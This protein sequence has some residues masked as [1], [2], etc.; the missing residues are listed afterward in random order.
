MSGLV[1]IL[2]KVGKRMKYITIL[3]ISFLV[4]LTCIYLMYSTTSEEN[5]ALNKQI[6]GT[7][8]D[9]KILTDGVK[10][11]DKYIEM[12]DFKKLEQYFIIVMGQARYINSIKLYWVKGFQ[13]ASYKVEV[14]K[15][16]FN[17]DL[18]G[19]YKKIKPVSEKGGLIVTRHF[20]ENKAAFFIKVTILQPK[21]KTVRISEVELF[22]EVSAILTIKNQKVLNIK[23]HSVDI[24]FNTSIAAV[25]YLRFGEGK[26]SLT[27]NIGMKMDVFAKHNIH[28][29]NLLKGTVYFYQP[30]TRDLNGKTVIGKV[31][32]FKT[33]G[34]PL[35][36][37]K[38]VK[39]EEIQCF[40][41]KLRWDLNVPCRNELLLG[42]SQKDLKSCYK[43]NQM[44]RKNGLEISKL[45][46]ET[47]FYF[48][49]ISTDKFQNKIEHLGDF[50]TKAENIALKK[51]VY[52]TFY[53][54]PKARGTKYDLKLF[55]RITDGNYELEGI[56]SSG[57]LNNKDQIA[58]VDLKKIFKIRDI[59]VLWR[60][61]AYSLKFN[62]S[63]SKDMKKWQLI[64]KNINAKKSGKRVLSRGM[65]GLFLKSVLI[66]ANG[67]QARYIKI[68][69]PKGSKVGSDL[70]YDTL[71]YLMLAEIEVFKVPDYAPPEYA[72]RKI[73]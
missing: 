23:E 2:I 6:I 66:K 32:S 64:K 38:T 13:P 8:S 72:V 45:V 11:K 27:Q 71:P 37:Y 40:K 48:K 33:K 16:L 44:T 49:I 51:R 53:Y 34:I 5:I 67:R 12:K 9:L 31:K 58:I 47:K 61:I 14:S 65:Q 63:I 43:N 28:A 17:W 41:S 24:I 21:A 39:S 55:K 20:L 56:S 29:D 18:I 42:I 62:V 22:R 69:A 1:Y 59:I 52:G 46:P 4:I 25:G 57:N 7:V 30:V 73:K 68:T 26:N 54:F 3:T 35:P 15:S 36:R 19:V 70:P 10:N 50:N 60:G